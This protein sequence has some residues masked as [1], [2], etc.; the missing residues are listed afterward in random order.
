[1]TLPRA[2]SEAA[3]QAAAPRQRIVPHLWFDGLAEEAARH[4]ASIFPD[5]EILAVSRYGSE[6]REV[7]G[8]PEGRAMNV[9]FSL[10]GY[11]L[12]ALNGGPG[13]DFTP[14]LSFF[15][16]CESGAEVD[17]IFGRLAEGGRELLE[18]GPSPFSERYGWT[19]DRFGVTWQVYQGSLA[20]VHGQKIIPALTFS[21]AAGRA[22]EA[23]R[24]Y[25]GIFP[26]SSVDGVLTFGDTGR[27]P[28][29]HVAHAQFLLDGQPFMVLD[30]ADGGGW[31]FNEAISLL[32]SC[33]DQ[34]EIDH[35]W[36]ELTSGQNASEQRCGW[37]VDDFGVS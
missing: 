11:R 20:D 9:D 16:T 25:T 30:D 35:Y 8:Q 22:H 13:F 28:A 1:M 27:E 2:G 3:R 31:G 17:E 10:A 19:A 15:V 14:A 34:A 24:R 5:S 33:R 36:Q 29:H 6:G 4:Y 23:L 18:L 12:L 7:H 37:L 32:V 21:A 26:D